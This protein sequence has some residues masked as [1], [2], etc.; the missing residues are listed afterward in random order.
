M[1]APIYTYKP[2]PPEA[3]PCSTCKH[4]QFKRGFWGI[5]EA[6]TL[7][8]NPKA[9]HKITGAPADAY[10]VRLG[11]AQSQCN[12][13]GLWWETAE[14]V[15]A[16]VMRRSRGVSVSSGETSYEPRQ[17]SNPPPDYER[18]SPPPAPPASRVL[19]H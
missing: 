3:P 19:N 13:E 16:A 4:Y 2:V 14:F 12:V 11:A 10:M 8:Q 18:P 17:G 6:K 1:V 5:T 7:C 15:P 9:V